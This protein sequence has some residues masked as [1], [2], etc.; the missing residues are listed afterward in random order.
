MPRDGL[1]QY[2]PPPGTN[3]ITNYTIE[4][5]KYNGFVADVTQDLNLPRPIVA[6]GTGANNAHDAMIALSGEIT[7]QQVTN[8]DSFPFV[9]GSFWSAP[10]ATSAPNPTHYF[11]GICYMS[12][13]LITLEAR[14]M[15]DPAPGR[16]Y[17]REYQGTTWSAWSVQAGSVADLDAAYVN[18]AGD[19]MTGALTIG[20]AAGPAV[21]NLNSVAGAQAVVSF[22]SANATKWQ[23]GKQT[24]DSIFLYD[25]A[26][27]AY[28]FNS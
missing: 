5:T 1:Q 20:P 2:T 26:G 28:V 11:V 18:V 13:A 12:G 25:I 9:A 17:V 10:G 14:D 24:D 15:G 6:G 3:G 23:L 4:S 16:K 22:L 19:T 8:Y 27:A 7:N 21:L